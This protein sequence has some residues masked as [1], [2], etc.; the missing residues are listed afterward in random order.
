MHG[1]YS[2][3][4]ILQAL[5]LSSVG[6]LAHDPILFV[7]KSVLSGIISKAQAQELNADALINYASIFTPGGASGWYW[8]LPLIPNGTDV[9]KGGAGINPFLGNR[10]KNN[11]PNFD[12]EYAVTK[13]GDYYLPHI[14]NTNIPTMAGDVKMS[15]IADNMLMMRGIST[16]IDGHVINPV[17]QHLPMPGKPSYAGLAADKSA[18]PFPAVGL[19]APSN[20]NDIYQSARGLTLSTL[21]DGQ[22]NTALDYLLA[23]FNSYPGG[24]MG[25][26]ATGK[27]EDLIGSLMSRI[28]E[29]AGKNPK[30]GIEGLAKIYGEVKILNK[31]F[32]HRMIEAARSDANV[33]ALVNLNVFALMVPMAAEKMLKE[34]APYFSAYLK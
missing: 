26:D 23:P 22:M 17:I 3:R 7:M 24:G 5:G 25:G 12:L 9:F 10:L 4:K 27:T 2:R 21:Q 28:R 33:H 32:G 15:S 20:V 18:S 29:Q 14:W 13:V 19:Y 34:M 6:A 16:G 8:D 11:Y 1:Q 31:D 30:W